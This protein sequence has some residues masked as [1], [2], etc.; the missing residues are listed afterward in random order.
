MGGRQSTRVHGQV[1]RQ[2]ISG[3][4]SLV[5]HGSVPPMRNSIVGHNG[6]VQRLVKSQVVHV[7]RVMPSWATHRLIANV[8]P[9]KLAHLG[10]VDATTNVRG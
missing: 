7:R 9:V 6:M 1:V 8:P 2:S 5:H 4:Q 3:V 10:I